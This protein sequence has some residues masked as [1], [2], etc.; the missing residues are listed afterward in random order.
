MNKKYTSYNLDGCVWI[1]IR[2]TYII[3]KEVCNGLLRVIIGRY[4][5]LV[6]HIKILISVAVFIV[7]CL[8]KINY[9]KPTQVKFIINMLYNIYFWLRFGLANAI[10]DYERLKNRVVV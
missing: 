1:V 9:A 7:C 5:F 4:F 2:Y 3:P 10:N 8:V 6:T